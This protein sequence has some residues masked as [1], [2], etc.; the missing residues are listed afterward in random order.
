MEEY[1]FYSSA[2]QMVH[3]TLFLTLIGK[4]CRNGKTQ[5]LILNSWG[6]GCSSYKGV[7]G[8]ECES[9]SGKFWID[10]EFLAGITFAFEYG[11]K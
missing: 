4:R 6:T 10:E 2:K 1:Y 9:G 7:R 5:Y 8:I 3:G 11:S